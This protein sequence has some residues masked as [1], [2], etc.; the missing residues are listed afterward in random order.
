MKEISRVLEILVYISLSVTFLIVNFLDKTDTN[1]AIIVS[2]ILIVLGLLTNIIYYLKNKRRRI[3]SRI[4]SIIASMFFSLSIL[5]LKDIDII[6]LAISFGIA[7]LNL[8]ASN[9]ILLTSKEKIERSEEEK[10]KLNTSLKILL[11]LFGL[12][13]ISLLFNVD[14]LFGTF[15]IL[16]IIEIIYLK[17][18][19]PEDDQLNGILNLIISLIILG[20]AFLMFAVKFCVEIIK[21]IIEAFAESAKS[22]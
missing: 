1:Y 15:F 6:S 17:I 19:Y 21:I 16:L 20:F 12:F 13:A 8:I 3:L 11:I 14:I 4:F 22:L 2:F 5:N 7:S 18:K 10:R 9:I